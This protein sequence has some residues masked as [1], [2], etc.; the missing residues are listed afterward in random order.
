MAIELKIL[1]DAMQFGVDNNWSVIPPNSVA[2]F[3]DAFAKAESDRLGRISA[4]FE[5]LEPLKESIPDGALAMY[6]TAAQFDAVLLFRQWMA[7]EAAFVQTLA[8]VSPD[9][10]DELLAYPANTDMA[11]LSDR[12]PEVAPTEQ[13]VSSLSPPAIPSTDEWWPRWALDVYGR[14]LP[15]PI[16]PD[17][18]LKT[19]DKDRIV[20]IYKATFDGDF[21]NWE[22]SF[23]VLDWLEKFWD[24]IEGLFSA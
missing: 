18:P 9:R 17:D 2:Y 4:Y 7:V 16:I 21:G 3:L 24:F 22:G 10:R 15:T 19:P 23:P 8:W 5:R 6:A 13:D 11:V 12:F 1:H 14:A 20:P